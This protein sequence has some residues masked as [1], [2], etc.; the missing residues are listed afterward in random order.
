[1]VLRMPSAPDATP[2]AIAQTKYQSVQAPAAFPT[3]LAIRGGLSHHQSHTRHCR[4]G[5][6]ITATRMSNGD[7][8]VVA[9]LLGSNIGCTSIAIRMIKILTKSKGRH[10]RN[11][12]L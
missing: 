8:L 1:M 5:P 3:V 9:S 7:H 6:A 12:G 2:E 11:Q 4:T 10:L